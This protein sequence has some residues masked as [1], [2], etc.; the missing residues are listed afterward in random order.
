[1]GRRKWRLELHSFSG[2]VQHPRKAVAWDMWT[3]T[4]MYL[5]SLIL[6][7]I[8]FLGFFPIFF[9]ECRHSV[10]RLT[11]SRFRTLSVEPGE[12]LGSG[13]TGHVRAMYL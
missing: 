8:G 12:P 3:Y 9:K 10:G 1:M 7:L 13:R 4:S 5:A 2:L 6:A 11:S